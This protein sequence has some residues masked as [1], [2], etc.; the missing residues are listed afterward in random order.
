MVH[1]K[2]ACSG[3]DGDGHR[4]NLPEAGCR[5]QV[6]APGEGQHPATQPRV[7]ED[8]CATKADSWAG[9]AQ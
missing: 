7:K 3:R 1:S 8:I 6:Q 9:E 2:E 5:E 4:L